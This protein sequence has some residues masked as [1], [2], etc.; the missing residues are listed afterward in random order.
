MHGLKGFGLSIIGVSRFFIF[1]ALIISLLFSIPVHVEAQ[2]TEIKVV[3]PETD[4][5]NFLFYTNTTFKDNH[6]NLTLRVYNVNNL[7]SFQVF[8]TY[9]PTLLNATRAWLP[10]TNTDYVFFGKSAV[11]PPPSFY[12]NHARWGYSVGVGDA[13]LFGETPF[14]G[15]GLLAIVEFRI[16]YEPAESE[17][18]VSG[19]FSYHEDTGLFDPDQIEIAS[20]KTNGYYQYTWVPPPPDPFLEAKPSR[21]DATQQETFNITVWLNN[22]D[23]DHELVNITFKLKYDPT[24][25]NVAQAIEGSFLKNIGNT[26]FTYT[27]GTGNITIMNYLETPYPTFPEGNGEIAII[28]FQGIRQ[29]AEEH[30]SQLRFED[31]HLLNSTMGQIPIILELTKHSL[32]TISF[33]ESQISIN[34]DKT[35]VTIGSNITFSGNIS[36]P[37]NDVE[38]TI[39]RVTV[40]TSNWGNI[41]KIRTD[42]DGNYIYIWTADQWGTWDFRAIWDGDE[43]IRGAESERIEVKV[44]RR[45]STLT[46]KLDPNPVVL[47][48]NVTITGTLKTLPFETK[49]SNA[50][51]TIK[52]R[53]SNETDWTILDSVLTDSQGS[54]G[55]TWNASE[56]ATFEFM[57]GW[58]GD[59]NTLGSDSPVE[60]LEVVE[61]LPV[62]YLP[63][64]AGGIVLV[65]VIVAL[66]V[67]FKKRK[68]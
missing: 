39:Q 66:I 25:L 65:I 8:L 59:T 67:Y 13:L 33:A 18:F 68:P 54:Y 37:K 6:F 57:A 51:L 61:T 9:D 40:G 21:Y 45:G 2:T 1:F 53:R 62:D 64:I 31:I 10:T 15:N 63:F 12:Y 30:S 27:L 46:L 52:Y 58:P 16:I 5:T 44:D 60:T 55:L 42:E 28:T 23:L 4:N 32:Y 35:A 38:V 3:N 17:S 7:D 36:P 19:D 48:N 11:G 20:T 50:N 49:I 26:N 56:I 43:F 34:A 47:G 14:D 41:S 22:I 24:L 29:D